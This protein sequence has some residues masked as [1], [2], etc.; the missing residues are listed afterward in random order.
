MRMTLS[1][2]MRAFLGID[3]LVSRGEFTQLHEDMVKN[4][5][6]LLNILAHHVTQVDSRPILV[7][8]PNLFTSWDTMQ[9]QELAE[10][11]ANQPK[12]ES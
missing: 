8:R 10:M 7:A 2:R 1:Q 6:Q 12:E 9:L 3:A 4:H 5:Q 11:I